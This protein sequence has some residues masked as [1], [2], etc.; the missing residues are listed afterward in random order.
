MSTDVMRE[1]IAG[2]IRALER[3]EEAGARGRQISAE[4]L[5]GLIRENEDT[6][7]GRKYGF[8]EI[9]SY[10]DYAARVPYSTYEDYEPYIERMLCFRQKNLITAREVVYYAH[11]S[12]TTGASKMIP[13][14]REALE[15]LFTTVFQ[16]VFGAYET[17]SRTSDGT[18]MPDCRGIGLV[19]SRIGYTPYGVA[20]GAISEIMNRPEDLSSFNALPEELICPQAEF[21]RRHVK[22]LFALRERHLSFFLSTFSPM[23]YDML[24][25][26]RHHWRMLC[27]DLEAGRIRSEVTVDPR[28]RKELDKKL[29]PD[30]E[31]AA[32][33]RQIMETHEND[34][35]VPLLWPDLKRIATVGAATFAPYIDKLRP[36]LGQG[37]SVDYLGYV[38]S[39]ATIGAPMHAEEPFYM[40][41]PFGG[42]YEFLPMEEDAPEK[43]LLMDELEVGKEYELVVT[44]LSGFYRYRL[45]DVIRVTGYHGECPLIVFSY[46]KNQLISMYGEKVTET[47]LRSAVEAMAEESGTAVTEYSVY[48]DMGT[49]PGHYTVLLESDREI[50]PET[51]PRCSEILNRKLCEVHESYRKKIEGGIMLPL[52]VK[53]VQ[54]QTYALYRDLKVMGGASPNQIKP[55][56]VIPE[57]RLKR[58]FFG[59]LQT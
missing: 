30:P 10:A 51:W 48:A 22:M 8:R 49:D 53:F 32:E 42:F 33:I 56:H 6:E 5:M 24:V 31:R 47:A 1:Y 2:G 29:S 55:I 52:E 4:T 25:Y 37:I 18:G 11:T 44:N 41:L 12:G 43:P 50:L 13:C 19:E 3:M 38:C 23:I 14:T 57:G 9:R 28:L 16:R 34:A 39:E 45:G 26:V 20:H 17:E 36:M 27:E 59:L 46:R 15:I 40:L 7:Y 54:P 21:D 35:F 58:F